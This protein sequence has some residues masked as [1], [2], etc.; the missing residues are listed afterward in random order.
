MGGSPWGG[1]RLCSP[2]GDRPLT[3][4]AEPQPLELGERRMRMA[5]FAN[6]QELLKVVGVVGDDLLEPAPHV[7]LAH[8]IVAQRSVRVESWEP[9]KP[10]VGGRQR[11]SDSSRSKK[12]QRAV[13]SAQASLEGFAGKEPSQPQR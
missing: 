11:K 3:P 13:D 10:E 5:P 9:Q 2:R 6:D 7:A 12:R 8:R 4:E 1:H